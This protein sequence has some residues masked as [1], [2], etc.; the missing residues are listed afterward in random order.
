MAP[1]GGFVRDRECMIA[2]RYFI[3]SNIRHS[4]LP[5]GI[6]I[7][8]VYTDYLRYLFKHTKEF[9]G[10]HEDQGSQDWETLS[11]S[12]DIVLTHPNGWGL[13]EQATL[14]TA[15]ISAGLFTEANSHR[16]LSFVSEAEASIHFCIQDAQLA[17]SLRVCASFFSCLSGSEI[18]IGAFRLV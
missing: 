15:A 17:S 14:R 7:I 11:Q 2:I 1:A 9:F 13:R 18:L 3:A 5:V 10:L 6:D 12:M 16:Q 8:R 4:A